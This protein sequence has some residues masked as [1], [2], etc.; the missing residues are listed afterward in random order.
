MVL[1]IYL[2]REM[3]PKSFPNVEFVI[4]QLNKD[5]PQVSASRVLAVTHLDDRHVFVP[6]VS[7]DEQYGICY[8][9]WNKFNWK[10]ARI[11]TRGMPHIWKLNGENPSDYYIVWN[12]DPKDQIKQLDYYLKRERHYSI[13]QNSHRYT[14]AIQTRTTALLEEQAFGAIPLPEEWVHIMSENLRVPQDN[15]PRSFF[16]QSITYNPMYIGWIPYNQGREVVFPANSVNGSGYT[17]RD[18]D[19][20]F[21]R[22]MNEY[23]LELPS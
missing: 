8:W 5:Y 10:L 16:N 9:V 18:I 3:K 23:E 11:D 14:P 17:L 7:S 21:V 19:L 15:Q 1:I 12:I 4:E 2:N 20:D 22:I 13:S 6:Y